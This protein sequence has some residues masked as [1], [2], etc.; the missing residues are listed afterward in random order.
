MLS[1]E[2]LDGIADSVNPTLGIISLAVPW[3]VRKRSARRALVISG[4]T[5]V[6]VGIA[7]VMQ[8]V[9]SATGIWP[10]AGMDFSTHTAVFVAIASSLWQ[11]GAVWRWIVTCV[12]LAYATLMVM[13]RYHSWFDIIST[14]LALLPLLFLLW[15]I[16]ARVLRSETLA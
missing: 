6:A 14:G 11:H 8:A 5:L 12:G 3:L 16:A 2:T 10:H 1:Y 9:D 4:A 13:Q 7:Y 15:W